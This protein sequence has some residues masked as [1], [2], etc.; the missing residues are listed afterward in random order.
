MILTL[1]M[2]PAIDKTLTLENFTIN[3]VNKVVDVRLD[4]AGKGINVS[5]VVKVLGGRTKV[6]AFLGGKNGAFI[7]KALE[8]DR[9]SLVKIPIDNETRINTKIVDR[10]LNTYTDINELGPYIKPEHLELF[11]KQ[12]INY[13]SSDAMVVLTGSVPPGVHE[14]VYKDLIIKLKSFGVKTV[15]DA[16]GP[17]F[18]NAL[19][20]GPYLIKPNIHEL[21][22]YLQK[23]N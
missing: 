5:K 23:K 19:E 13:A 14:N 7:S 21:E 2:N 4:P 17:L 16:S 6:I 9:L 11:L 3:H 8:E 22:T 20:G 1:A 15:L 18:S 12:T 10:V